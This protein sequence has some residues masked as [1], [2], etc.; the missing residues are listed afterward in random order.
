MFK[1][2]FKKLPIPF[3]WK[4]VAWIRIALWTAL[5]PWYFHRLKSRKFNPNNIPIIINNR[6]RLFALKK[7]IEQ[8]KERGYSNIIVLDNDSSFPPLLD[9]Y[10]KNSVKVH[11]LKQNLGYLALWKSDLWPEIREQFYIYTDPDV[12]LIEQCPKDFVIQLFVTLLRF[13]SAG[14]VGLGIKI[15]DIPEHYPLKNEVLSREKQYWI[16]PVGP[17]IYLAPIDTTF[18][19]YRPK[20]QGGYWL[21]ALRLGGDCLLKHLPWYEDENNLSEEESFYRQHAT[22]DSSWSEA[23]KKNK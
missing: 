11:Y 1:A 20:A 19:L 18:A 12:I 9:F 10:R 6:N 2:A 21:K 23:A 13:P 7:L 3:K 8:L 4:I 22:S 14:K 16:N 15:D 17:Q 5:G